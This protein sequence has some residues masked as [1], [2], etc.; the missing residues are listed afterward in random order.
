MIPNAILLPPLSA[1][2]RAEY[3][4]LCS[5]FAAAKAHVSSYNSDARV[6]RKKEL[7]EKLRTAPHNQLL[8]LGAELETLEASFASAKRG[9]KH[10]L[11]ALSP[12]YASL[13]S[14]LIDR[15]QAHANELI[16][17]AK[18][19]WAKHFIAFGAEPVDESPIVA[20]LV[21]WKKQLADKRAAMDLM[22]GSGM[23]PL[24]PTA[25]LPYPTN[26]QPKQ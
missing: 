7:R 15:S 19:E 12:R 22:A 25:I 9:A 6:A 21:Q 18:T 11:R 4:S 10:R 2:D 17:K 13:F 20:F 8:S 23:A 24:P 1:K 16:A 5:D 3:D 14:R 26:N